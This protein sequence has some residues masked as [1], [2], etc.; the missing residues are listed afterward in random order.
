MQTTPRHDH[1]AQ[2]EIWTKEDIATFC[3]IAP[4]SVGRILRIALE[5]AVR[6]VAERSRAPGGPRLPSCQEN[7]DQEVECRETT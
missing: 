2:G 5:T 1:N 4:L 7:W 3:S 6:G